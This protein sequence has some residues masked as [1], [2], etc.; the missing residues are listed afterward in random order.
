MKKIKSWFNITFA[1]PKISYA[2]SFALG[3]LAVGLLFSLLPGEDTVDDIFMTGVM[4]DRA[5][6]RTY[7]LNDNSLEGEVKVKQSE[8]VVILDVDLKTSEQMD[9]ELSYDKNQFALYG[10]K[11]VESVDGGKFASHGS[12]IRLSNL[13]S[14]HYLVFLRFLRNDESK[15]NASFYNGSITVAML[16]IDI[17]N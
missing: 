12:S 7:F 17:K 11:S 10:V 4:S 8:G 14:N 6:D 15:V 2:I 9:C 13:Q 3:A 5:F 16:T 1:G